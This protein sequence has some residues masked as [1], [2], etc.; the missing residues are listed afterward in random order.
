MWYTLCLVWFDVIHSVF[1]VISCD[2]HCVW[3]D[4]MWYTLC[5]VW[6]HVIHSVSDVI[7][8]DTL[9]VWCDLMW[10]TLCLVWFDVIHCVWCDLM[11]YTL[12]LVQ[13]SPFCLIWYSY[14]NYLPKH[15]HLLVALWLSG[16]LL[17]QI[18]GRNQNLPNK[19]KV[20]IKLANPK[21]HH[22]KQVNNLVFY[23]HSTITVIS[24]WPS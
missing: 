1:G 13:L 5:L 23:T 24:G 20:T 4:F 9:C 11:W 22:N 8:C 21:I 3:C 10:Y 15:S 16:Q 7:S 6:F 18:F 19:E 12:C 17:L 14:L 2:T